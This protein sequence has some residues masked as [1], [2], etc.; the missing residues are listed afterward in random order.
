MR[1]SDCKVKDGTARKLQNSINMV[2]EIVEYKKRVIV[3]SCKS[4]H[5]EHYT[6]TCLSLCKAE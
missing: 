2:L 3:I 6:S 4:S 1:A 5:T